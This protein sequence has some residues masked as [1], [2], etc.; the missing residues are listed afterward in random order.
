[1]GGWQTAAAAAAA[2]GRDRTAPWVPRRGPRGTWRA[3]SWRISNVSAGSPAFL[4]SLSLM[5][6]LEAA[7]ADLSARLRSAPHNRGG[8]AFWA[9]ELARPAR[10]RFGPL[11]A[12]RAA[13]TF[14]LG[15]EAD[16]VVLRLARDGEVEEESV[17]ADEGNGAVRAV[18]RRAAAGVRG[19]TCE[20]S[21]N[22]GTPSLPSAAVANDISWSSSRTRHES[23][24]LLSVD[25]SPAGNTAGDESGCRARLRRAAAVAH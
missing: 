7:H 1:M 14:N 17:L 6:E 3:S 11:R 8:Q 15:D 22:T 10:R 13:R 5:V 20:R 9:E 12:W 16:A 24:C 4:V 2:A 25:T 18:R 19:Q 23:A 21:P